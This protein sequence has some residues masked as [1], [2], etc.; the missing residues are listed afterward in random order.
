[1]SQ[2]HF[3]RIPRMVS[4]SIS[5]LS[6]DSVCAYES[7]SKYSSQSQTCNVALVSTLHLSA[8]NAIR[9]TSAS[10]TWELNSSLFL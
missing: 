2:M 1:M 10:A 3:F 7:M 9:F 8:W 6:S 4:L 5:F